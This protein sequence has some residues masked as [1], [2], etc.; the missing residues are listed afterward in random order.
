VRGHPDSARQ[1]AADAVRVAVRAPA[2]AGR[3]RDR[4][5]SVARAL[6]VLEAIAAAP[7]PLPAKEVARHLG[8][9]L[10]RS[11]H[12]LNTLEDAGYVVR[13]A[14]GRFGLGPKV[15]GLYRL[16]HARLDLVPTVR[17]LLDELARRAREDAYLALFR[18]GEVVVAEVVGASRE[19]HV[20][21]LEVGFTRVAHTTA[22]GKVVLAGAPE[23]AVD[24][25]LGERPLVPFTR[26]TLVERRH[27]KRHLRVVRERGIGKDLEELADGCCCVAVPVLDGRGATLGAI[28]LSTP[29]GRWRA[30]E[31]VLTELCCE[32]GARAS[33][34]VGGGGAPE[35]P[36]AQPPSD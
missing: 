5:S 12:I 20:D 27:I 31:A 2:A 30:D 16:F 4:L 6:D 15:P 9:S 26:R 35:P 34:L 7:A 19:L 28:G 13:L 22:I 36:L 17:P 23:E 18:D 14:Q 29:A 8:I 10:G 24:G 3:S 32:I 21:G 25:Y 11:Y 1:G 33:N